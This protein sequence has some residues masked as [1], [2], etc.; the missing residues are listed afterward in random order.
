[1]QS[2]I[3]DESAGIQ[4]MKIRTRLSFPG[5]M[6][7]CGILV[8][9]ACW[10]AGGMITGCSK[11]D[12]LDNL[13]VT[14]SDTT[15]VPGATVLGQLLDG[16]GFDGFSNFDIAQSEEFQNQGITKNQIEYAKLSAFTLRVTHPAGQDLSFLDSLKIFVAAENQP[17]R[18]VASGGNF[19]AGSA[20]VDLVLENVDLKPFITAPTA[21]FSTEVQG[22]RPQQES[23]IEAV[24]KIFVEVDVTGSLTG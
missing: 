18:L 14:L 1:M 9:F 11:L 5:G 16:L 19:P 7:L 4:P 13:T 10:L 3:C 23:S 6:S 17:P 2:E 15:Q 22:R 24:I 12:D 21:E 20:G 8:G